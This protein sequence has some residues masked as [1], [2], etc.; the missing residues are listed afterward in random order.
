MTSVARTILAQLG[1]NRFITVTG[2]TNLVA[3][4]RALTLTLPP[5]IT[6]GRANRLRV[7]LTPA[8][9][10]RVETLR[11]TRS[12][13]VVPCGLLD[14]VDSEALRSAVEKLTG[15]RTSL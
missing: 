9:L 1:G 14:D 4:D 13:D 11:V 5:S 7:T 6:K 10:Y 15:L 3:S 8:D 2:A 12:W